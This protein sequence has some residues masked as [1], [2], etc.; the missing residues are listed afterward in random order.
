[1][2]YSTMNQLSYL[3]RT[4]WEYRSSSD[5]TDVT[6]FCAD[7]SLPSHVAILAPMF[8]RFNIRFP[9][10]GELPECIFIPD[11]TTTEVKKTLETLYLKNSGD[12]LQNKREEILNAENIHVEEVNN[13]YDNKVPIMM[14]NSYN[15]IGNHSE[16]WKM[17][18]VRS[19]IFLRKSQLGHFSCNL[20]ENT[21]NKGQDY[22][23]HKYSV[24]E[25]K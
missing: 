1:M 5:Y 14:E 6:L 16:N 10:R 13:D 7:G 8:E 18:T 24:H 25:Q 22:R 3:S 19:V 4:L 20:C 2:S 12:V 15:Y 23:K 21:F 11:L 9:F 17:A